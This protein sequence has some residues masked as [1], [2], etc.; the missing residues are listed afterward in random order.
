[1]LN[2]LRDGMPILPGKRMILLLGWVAVR[3]LGSW[4]SAASAPDY[5]FG[6]N[7]V[8][9]VTVLRHPEW[10]V[11]QITVNSAGKISLPVVGEIFVA[12][13]SISQVDS[14]ITR[15]LVKRIVR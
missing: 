10:S 12:G 15:A 11:D 8:I 2:E 14:E 3:V 1:M 9:S 7:D 6:P 5:R 4:G 13:K